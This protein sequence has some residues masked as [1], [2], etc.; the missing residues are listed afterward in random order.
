[1]AE[2]G[3]L[4]DPAHLGPNNNPVMNWNGLYNNNIQR[5][6]KE[7][8]RHTSLFCGRSLSSAKQTAFV[9]QKLSYVRALI[10]AYGSPLFSKRRFHLYMLKQIF[11]VSFFREMK[12]RFQLSLPRTI[13]FLGDWSQW[14]LSR[15]YQTPSL[16]RGWIRELETRGMRILKVDEYN[17][18]R[19]CFREE[20]VDG[21]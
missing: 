18:S 9:K 13:V 4:R 15:K 3:E 20:C 12:A 7:W 19:R 11:F 1:M 10:T 17:S 8:D 16:G 6:V 21:K 5:T 2:R 14:G